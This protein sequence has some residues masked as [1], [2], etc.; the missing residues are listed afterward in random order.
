VNV[1]VESVGLLPLRETPATNRLVYR[2]VNRSAINRQS[3]LILIYPVKERNRFLLLL[4]RWILA[5]MRRH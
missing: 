3:M 1:T 2:N 4:I 5:V